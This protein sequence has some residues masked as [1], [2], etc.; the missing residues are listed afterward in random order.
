MYFNEPK[1]IKQVFYETDAS[2][3]ILK[4][5]EPSVYEFKTPDGNSNVY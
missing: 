5:A 2:T 1:N 3:S 4:N